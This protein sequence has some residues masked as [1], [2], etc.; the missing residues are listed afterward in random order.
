LALRSYPAS[1]GAYTAARSH[2][3]VSRGLG[4]TAFPLRLG[5]W[6]EVVVIDCYLERAQGGAR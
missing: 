5:T 6:P 4:T 2:L 3:F 1:S